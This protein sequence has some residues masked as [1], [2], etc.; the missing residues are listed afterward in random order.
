MPAPLEVSHALVLHAL[1]RM[2]RKA[3]KVPKNSKGMLSR[4]T[5]SIPYAHTVRLPSIGQVHGASCP[6]RCPLIDGSCAVWGV[7]ARSHV[8]EIWFA[9][10]LH[11][12][13]CLSP[14]RD[15]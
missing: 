4:P 12:H 7:P 6:V 14:S 5:E 11:L 2:M 10:L 8:P 15:H 9:S 3:F 13:H 1:R